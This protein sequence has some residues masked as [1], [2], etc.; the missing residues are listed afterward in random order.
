MV[1]ISVGGHLGRRDYFV[2]TH[3]IFEDS[4]SDEAQALYSRP[5]KSASQARPALQPGRGRSRK[6]DDEE[7]GARGSDFTSSAAESHP[8]P[9]LRRIRRLPEARQPKKAEEPLTGRARVPA[10]REGVLKAKGVFSP[11]IREGSGLREWRI[12]RTR[13]LPTLGPA[14]PAPLD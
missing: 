12:A 2:V 1:L 7:S 3:Q 4:L 13:S 14:T 5:L 11:L 9:R 6:D 10:R 8:S